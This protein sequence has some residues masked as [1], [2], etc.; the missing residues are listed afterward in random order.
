MYELIVKKNV[1]LFIEKG[2]HLLLSFNF[3]VKDI[4]YKKYQKYSIIIE[5][6]LLIKI[7]AIDGLYNFEILKRVKSSSHSKISK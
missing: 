4:L 1:R 3:G 5:K 2:L 7:N 6:K